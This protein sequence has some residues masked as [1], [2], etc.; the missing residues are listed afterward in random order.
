MKELRTGRAAA[1]VLTVAAVG[2]LAGCLE[3]KKVLTVHEDGSGTIRFEHS[4]KPGPMARPDRPKP[5]VEEVEKKWHGVLA[6]WEGIVAWTDVKA[7]VRDGEPAFAAVGWFEDIS[8]TR[9]PESGTGSGALPTWTKN[10]DGTFTCEFPTKKKGAQPVEKEPLDEKPTPPFMY[11]A[12]KGLRIEIELRAPG[13]ITDAANLWKVDG[14]VATFA[15]VGQELVDAIK[16][17]EKERDAAKADVEAGKTTREDANKKLKARQEELVPIVT[18]EKGKAPMKLTCKGG[19]PAT[20]VEAWK[21][22]LA[23]AKKKYA[24]SELEKKIK[25]AAPPK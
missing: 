5:T 4:S 17:Y 15:L 1:A 12:L 3:E 22:S 7:E 2:A 9:S 8:K 11:D 25:A 24:G 16:A 18:V 20:E 14:R 13:A 6:Q 10:A 23:E 21:A 19:E